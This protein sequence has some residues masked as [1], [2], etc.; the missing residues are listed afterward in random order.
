MTKLI[1]VKQTMYI[2]SLSNYG[3]INYIEINYG[4]TIYEK[5]N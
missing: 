5:I 4:L 3:L 2:Y 1:M